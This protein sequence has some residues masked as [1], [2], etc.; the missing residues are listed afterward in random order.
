MSKQY[1]IY[2]VEVKEFGE[3]KK[4]KKLVLQ[5]EGAQYPTKGVA[6]WDNHPL[7]DTIE[8]GQTHTLDIKVEETT[9]KN[10]H[11]GYYKNRSVVNPANVEKETAPILLVNSS[12]GGLDGRIARL[13]DAVFVRKSF[14]RPDEMDDIN[15][16]NIP[17]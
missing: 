3:G 12:H 8:A 13:E 2:E 4:M 7:F 15:P 17:F 10:P 1:K 5:E 6:M 9:N 14:G 16:D 11:G